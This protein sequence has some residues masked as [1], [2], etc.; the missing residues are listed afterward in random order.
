MIPCMIQTVRYARRGGACTMRPE[1]KDTEGGEGDGM[2]REWPGMAVPHPCMT[3]DDDL[4]GSLYRNLRD[5]IRSLCAPVSPCA[6]QNGGRRAG[7]PCQQDRA[8]IATPSVRAHVLGG[9]AEADHEHG[10]VIRRV[11]AVRVFQELFCRLAGICHSAN[12]L[13]C[14]L[15]A[16]HVPQLIKGEKG[17]CMTTS[18]HVPHRRP[19]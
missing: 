11:V 7:A 8:P 12:Q 1:R 3:G 13:D 17:A 16:D 18:G 14:G 19:G 5:A 9:I 6:C 10:D 2:R 15:V 4:G